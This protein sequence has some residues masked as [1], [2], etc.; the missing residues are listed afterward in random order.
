MEHGWFKMNR[1]IFTDEILCYSSEYLAVWCYLCAHAVFKEQQARFN[2]KVITLQP[3]QL[4]TGRRVIAEATK[5]NE[6]K[7]QRILS[8]FESA[9]RIAQQTCSLNRL[10]T[11]LEP[12]SVPL[13]AQ[14]T[15]Q[16][17]HGGCTSRAQPMHTLKNDKNEQNEKKNTYARGRARAKEK[18]KQGQ[19]SVYSCDASYDLAAWKK[20]NMDRMLNYERRGEERE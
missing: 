17:A 2:G 13:G 7:V 19:E 6:F 5:L 20:A 15:S 8:F 11:I 16:P 1:E 4:I 9:Q 12:D 10:I 18:Y 3:G 14:Q